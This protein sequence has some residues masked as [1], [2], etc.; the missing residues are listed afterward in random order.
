MICEASQYNGETSRQKSDN[1]QNSKLDLLLE[2][3]WYSEHFRLRLLE[4]RH[5]FQ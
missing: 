5:C 2:K 1:N 4:T 3:R